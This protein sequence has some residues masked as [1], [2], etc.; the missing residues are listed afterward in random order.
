MNSETEQKIIE[1]LLGHENIAGFTLPQLVL[2]AFGFLFWT[3]AYLHIAV[4]GRRD[5]INEMPMLAAAG[6]I[7]WEILWTFVFVGPLGLLFQVGCGCWLAVDIFINYQIITKNYKVITEPFIRKYFRAIHLF[8]FTVFLF[9]L[10]FMAREGKDNSLGVES[11]LLLNLF[12]SGLYLYQMFQRPA[13][14]NKMYSMKIAVYKMLGTITITISSCFIWPEDLYLIS[15]GV[16]TVILDLLYIYLFATYNPVLI[17]KEEHMKK[18]PALE[19]DFFGKHEEIKK[20][21]GNK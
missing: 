2:F 15:L 17:A 7:A 11:G 20:T 3:L 4:D 19:F 13:F 5:E 1:F 10:Y 18:H 21:R 12:M 8:F 16:A 9:V 14:R 6:N